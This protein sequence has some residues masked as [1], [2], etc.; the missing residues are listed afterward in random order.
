MAHEIFKND[1]D[2]LGTVTVRGSG[3]EIPKYDSLLTTVNT[4]SGAWESTYSTIASNSATWG[5]GSGDYLPLSGGTLTGLVSS[6]NTII[7]DTSSSNAAL[8][9]TQRGNGNV[10]LVEDETNP[11]STPL[12]ITANGRLG[13]G[14]LSPISKVG[15]V[16]DNEN[17]FRISNNEAHEYYASFGCTLSAGYFTAGTAI[18]RDVPL[19]F[20]TSLQ[21]AET[22][23][24]RFTADGK[25]GIGT[26]EP[27]ERLTVTG[28]ISSA[29]ILYASGGNS[30]R[31]SST[32]STVAS[33]SGNWQNTYTAVYANSSQWGYST[34]VATSG[35]YYVAKN[36]SDSYAGT[37]AAPFL[38]VQ[39]AINQIPA[40]TTDY[41]IYVAPGV[42][43][44]NLTINRVNV[45][46][47]GMSSDT[48]QAKACE[49]VGNVSITA[50]IAPGTELN[51]LI[52]FNN[53]LLRNVT[54]LNYVISSTGSGYSLLIKNSVVY[55]SNSGYGAV[56]ISHGT[57]ATRASFYSSIIQVTGANRNAL[58]ISAGTI[59]KIE[60]CQI[61]ALG[62]G[63]LAINATSGNAWI[64]SITGT[65]L[66][67]TGK[68]VSLA[69]N[70]QSTSNLCAF[71]SCTI[72][73][74]P[75]S[76]TTGIISLGGGTQAAFSF[77]RCNITNLSTSGSSD[78]PYFEFNTAAILICINNTFASI[79]TTA[80]NFRPVYAVTTA[81]P[82]AV[83]KYFDNSFVSNKSTGTDTTIIPVAGL[84]GWAIVERIITEPI[85]PVS[86]TGVR[87]LTGNWQNTYTTVQTVSSSWISGSFLPLS[88]G[89]IAGNL[90]ATGTILT[91]IPTV[92]GAVATKGYVDD[93][94]FDY[95]NDWDSFQVGFAGDSIALGFG[96]VDFSLSPLAWYCY[97]MNPKSRK[98]NW[99]PR[100]AYTDTSPFTALN[101]TGGYNFAR[102]SE[103]SQNLTRQLNLIAQKPPD[104]LLLQIGSNDS[105]ASL[106]ST[107]TNLTAVTAFLDGVR[108][109]RVKHTVVFPV[110]P[111]QSNSTSTVAR[112]TNEYNKRIENYCKLNYKDLTFFDNFRGIVNP[113]DEF[114]RPVGVFD[115]STNT[116]VTT[117]GLHFSTYGVFQFY[118]VLE[119]T[120]F[121]NL[122]T[123]NPKAT[124]VGDV[125]DATNN[126]RGN[127]LGR[128][129]IMFSEIGSSGI[130]TG[131]TLTNGTGISAI[132][133]RV[134]S[135]LYPGYTTQKLTLTGTPT[136]NTDRVTFGY[137]AFNSSFFNRG[138]TDHH[139]E[140]VYR[141]KS[142]NNLHLPAIQA[143][144]V[145]GGSVFIAGG[146]GGASGMRA[147]F[148]PIQDGYFHITS[149]YPLKSLTTSNQIQIFVN[150][151][152]LSGLP[153][154]GELEVGFVGLW[155]IS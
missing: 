81:V 126:I 107:N 5:T 122:P 6:N 72:Q 141:I 86:D 85:G 64:T 95:V 147:K 19:V 73:G 89:T 120:L 79:K 22:E 39:N 45:Q 48:E 21:G 93:L 80:V 41:T 135:E 97:Y 40:G 68:V 108:R 18:T 130:S 46:I 148:S 149:T 57:N 139:F 11:D 145:S 43:T 4:K 118:N 3:I 90:S 140:I 71:E 101:P 113:T 29:A 50:S 111:K 54:G 2:F 110:P 136:S 103:T 53:V 47:V 38:T 99:D 63:G 61:E 154:S 100:L 35:V 88:G 114:Y 7:L 10:L 25:V 124:N 150:I 92:S 96:T 44:E 59:R 128:N 142:F 91:G 76:S 115:G 1:V 153:V 152:G 16:E 49:I 104:I 129:G 127:I 109:A 17:A 36:G 23:K 78:F 56:N 66:Y 24:V 31:W 28:S 52:V 133:T 33:N 26:S 62:S 98:V 138:F 67:A 155:P 106:T 69:T 134:Q 121:K 151:H 12:V 132:P 117:D 146:G 119:N 65:T 20:R 42:Y 123:I 94:V 60:Q 30:D 70:N 137:T 8:R 75:Q 112:L 27:N 105:F 74:I 116:S 82:N 144:I 77:S 102:S 13:V 84:N 87:A 83:F 51:N 34:T 14:T 55:Q 125:W 58:D 9:I 131:W 143:Q 37:A 32:Y 15:I